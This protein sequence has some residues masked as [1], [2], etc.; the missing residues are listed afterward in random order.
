MQSGGLGAGQIPDQPA[1]QALQ[2]GHAVPSWRS[3]R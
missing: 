2:I 3:G 1:E